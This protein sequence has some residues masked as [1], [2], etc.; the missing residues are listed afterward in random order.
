MCVMCICLRNNNKASVVIRK[1]CEYSHLIDRY[2]ALV[3]EGSTLSQGKVLPQ[4][5]VKELKFVFGIVYHT[6]FQKSHEC[7]R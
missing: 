6:V 4:I 7:V 2:L 3:V 5:C 1:P